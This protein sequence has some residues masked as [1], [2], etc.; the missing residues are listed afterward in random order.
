MTSLDAGEMESNAKFWMKNSI[1]P[2]SVNTKFNKDGL[3]FGNNI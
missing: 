3:W 1:N 2:F